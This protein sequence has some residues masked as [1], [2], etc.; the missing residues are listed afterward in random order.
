MEF[1]GFGGYSV[2]QRD[3]NQP[4]PES[5]PIA[6]VETFAWT[7]LRRYGVMFRRLLAREAMDVPWRELVRVYRRLEARGEIRGG[8]FVTGMSG[9]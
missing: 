1:P 8:R 6:A 7:L 4:N 5:R 2:I 9:E 3:Q